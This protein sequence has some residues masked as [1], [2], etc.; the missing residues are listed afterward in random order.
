MRQKF[1]KKEKTGIIR[2]KQT[3]YGE[4]TSKKCKKLAKCPKI[5]KNDMKKI[6]IE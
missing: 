2:Q 5:N 3:K 6:N 4:K 1:K